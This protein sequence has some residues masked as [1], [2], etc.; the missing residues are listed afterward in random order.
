MYTPVVNPIDMVTILEDES[1]PLN[2]RLAGHQLGMT[3]LDYV[4]RV[5]P[6]YNCSGNRRRA[7]APEMV[8]IQTN[9][10]L[11]NK[12]KKSIDQSKSTFIF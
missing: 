1:I 6:F 4:K 8:K 12:T 5:A 3:R 2:I 7:P 9:E 11:L 10:S